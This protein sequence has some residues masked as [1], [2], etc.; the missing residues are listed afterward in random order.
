MTVL[1][2]LVASIAVTSVFPN[3]GTIPRRFT[4]DGADVVPPLTLATH[5][6]ARAYAIETIDVDAPGGRF[7]HWLAVGSVPGRNSFGKLGYSGPC[8]P[9][10][11]A[12]HRY[13]FHVYALDR[14]PSLRPG[15]TEAQLRKAM[16]GH[17]LASG[18]LVG[19]YRR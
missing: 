10:G 1:A 14:R 8:P 7:V 4:C 19:R 15:F 2:S 3:G 9:A 12:A 16:R 6:R 5:V 17:V 18:K 11:D 13:V